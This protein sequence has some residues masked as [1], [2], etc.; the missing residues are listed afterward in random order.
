M[1]H[2]TKEDRLIWLTRVFSGD[3]AAVTPENVATHIVDPTHVFGIELT[4]KRFPPLKRIFAEHDVVDFTLGAVRHTDPDRSFVEFCLEGVPAL[5]VVARFEVGSPHRMKYWGAYPP[6]PDGVV[7]RPYEAADAPGCRDLELRCPMEFGDGESWVIDRGDTFDDYLR[8]ADDF[9]ACVAVDEQ[10]RVIGFLS[11]ELRPISLDGVDAYCVYQHHYRVDPEFR[12]AS[13][14]MALSAHVDSRRTYEHL[15][16]R[17]PYSLIDGRNRRMQNLGMPSVDGVEIVR[18][19]V[20]I[21]NCRGGRK[22]SPDV[23]TICR[24]VNATH[25][26]RRFFQPY[27]GD[28]LRSRLGRITSYGLEQ[29]MANHGAVLG[30]WTA[31]ERNIGS[32]A[33]VVEER[34]L[35]FALDYG[36]EA[37]ADLVD[38]I[39]AVGPDLAEGGTT[40]LCFVMDGRASEASFLR[41]LAD[42]EQ[43]F[44]VHTLPWM[45]ETFAGHITYCDAVYC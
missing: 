38:L 25:A 41:E 17:F 32:R 35:A 19:A 36:F 26:D 43:R 4:S 16:V 29:F 31:F 12:G 8:L 6:L 1:T 5:I 37:E 15:D 22:R 21:A 45:G 14:S 34:R 11:N 24:L 42:D 7:V 13:V 39:D 18:L 3:Q 9:E 10:A 20:P 2:P 33:D 28:R 30:V 40:H 44:N 23:E 27:D